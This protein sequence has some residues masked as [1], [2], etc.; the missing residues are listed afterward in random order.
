MGHGIYQNDSVF[1]VGSSWHGLGTV[2]ETEQTAESAIKLAKMD[3][4]VEKEV[5]EKMPNKFYVKRTDTEE[6]FDIVGKNYRI[7]QNVEAFS[8]FDT[9]VGSGQAIYHSAGVLGKGDR[10]W[11]LAKLPNDIIL[12][13]DDV[14][15][16]Y[17]CFTNTHDGKGSVKMYFTPVRVVCQ[18]TLNLSLRAG[19]RQESV[20]FRHTGNIQLKVD[21][22]REALGIAIDFYNQ[23]DSIIGQFENTPLTVEKSDLF[24]NQVLGVTGTEDDSTRV[25]NQKAEVQTLFDCGK[26]QKLGNK[27]SLWKAVN[28]VTEYVDHH[29]PVKNLKDN[30]NNKIDSAWFGSGSVIKQKAFDLALSMV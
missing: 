13:S 9:V 1:T 6:Y 30:P 21:Q 25:L 26:G 23:F 11:I 12:N 29:R 5:T 3:Y 14:V 17:L 22:A 16:K 19:N 4:T 10:V 24:F 27:H 18:N 8:F 15:Q 2:V 28:A 20:S 7:V